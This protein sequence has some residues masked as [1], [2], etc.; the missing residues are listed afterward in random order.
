MLSPKE[1]PIEGERRAHRWG[2]GTA[3]AMTCSATPS[4]IFWPATTSERKWTP[5]HMRASA[6]CLAVT[7][8]QRGVAHHIGSKNG[9]KLAIHDGVL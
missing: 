9:S 8:H 1:A 5:A 4:P 6:A 7:V 2:G 3:N